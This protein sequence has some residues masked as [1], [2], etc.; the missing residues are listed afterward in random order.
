MKTMPLE[1]AR[2]YAILDLHYVPPERA[3]EMAQQLLAGGV[4]ALQLRAKSHAPE[5]LTSLA[6]AIARLCRKAGLPFII[7]DHPALASACEAD[8]VHVGQ[9]DMPLREVRALF[10]GFVGKSTHSF[11]Q[12]V[13]AQAEGADYIGFGPLFATP[14]KP[15]YQPVGLADIARVHSAVGIPIFCIGGINPGN[16]EAV[17]AAGARRVVMVSALL[18]SPD[19]RA[20]CAEVLRRLSGTRP[21]A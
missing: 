8:A 18:R 11:E 7:N 9:D 10:R 17:L 19:P 21:T 4:D 2:F 5:S 12:A 3:L 13:A 6:A 20:A 14:T 1:N 15:D 16:L